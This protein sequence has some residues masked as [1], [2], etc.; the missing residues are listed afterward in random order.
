MTRSAAFEKMDKLVA[1]DTVGEKWKQATL[2]RNGFVFRKIKRVMKHTVEESLKIYQRFHDTLEILN[3][4]DLRLIA[5]VDEVSLLNLLNAGSY[6]SLGSS[7]SP[8]QRLPWYPS[9][10]TR[11]AVSVCC[12][13]FL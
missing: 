2:R 13:K 11:T 8:R 3:N 5:N 6:N 1:P 4:H 10:S 7:K 12:G 9:P